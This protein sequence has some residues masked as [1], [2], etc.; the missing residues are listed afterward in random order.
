MMLCVL[1]AFPLSHTCPCSSPN[2]PFPT[3][4]SIP[5]AITS[6]FQ[7]ITLGGKNTLFS[8]LFFH[9][10]FYTGCFPS[11]CKHTSHTHTKLNLSHYDGHNSK[12]FSNEPCFRII[13]HLSMGGTYEYHRTAPVI[14]L[15]SRALLTFKKKR[16]FLMGLI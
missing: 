11:T 15:W 16:L 9:L 2:V 6:F 4:S 5:C 13:S 8:S 14:H 12:I 10:S 3:L 7:A 1:T